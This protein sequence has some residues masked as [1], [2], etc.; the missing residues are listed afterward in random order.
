MI[1]GV[2]KNKIKSA[3][4]KS[5]GNAIQKTLASKA[6]SALNKIPYTVTLPRAIGLDYQVT[7]K[8]LY[9]NG[10]FNV[11]IKGEFFNANDRKPSSYKPDVTPEIYPRNKMIHFIITDFFPL[12][13]G[14]TFQQKGILKMDVIDSMLPEGFPFRLFTQSF[15]CKC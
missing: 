12:T 11:P 7:K 9:G 6:N 1:I 13:A 3:I 5:V 10:F 14:E 4:E 8:I 2:F 15:K